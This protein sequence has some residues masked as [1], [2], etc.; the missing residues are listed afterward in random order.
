MLLEQIHVQLLL[1]CHLATFHTVCIC[2]QIKEGIID[3]TTVQI[4]SLDTSENVA[5]KI[6]YEFS[7]FTTNK[8]LELINYEEKLTAIGSFSISSGPRLTV[9][10]ATS[11]FS[12]V[13]M[14]YV[15]SFISLYTIKDVTELFT[16]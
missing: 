6:T 13:T 9:F 1:N 16:I 3:A 5:L 8:L 4:V 14:Y 15:H 11:E 12:I 2:W 10:E 7:A